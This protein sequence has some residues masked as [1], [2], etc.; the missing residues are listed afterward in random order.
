MSEVT[1]PIPDGID[2][3]GKILIT[4]L[5]SVFNGIVKVFRDDFG[6]LSAEVA[7]VKTELLQN[8]KC[9]NDKAEE[10]IAVSNETAQIVE[11]VRSELAE[12]K[13]ELTV[14]RE[15]ISDNRTEMT[16]LR[17]EVV[18]LKRERARVKQ[19]TNLQ[20][21]YSRRDNLTIRGIPELQQGDNTSCDQLLRN[22]FVGSMSMNKEE[23][24][25]M[26]FVRVHRIGKPLTQVQNR[27]LAPPR[28]IIVRFN[29]YRDRQKVW[30]CRKNLGNTK[31]SVNE[32]FPKS[33][34]YNRRKLYPIY[35]LAKRS[36]AL[37]EK[38]TLKNDVLTVDNE[39]F[40]VDTINKLP[41]QLHPRQLC[42]KTD[43]NTYAFGGLYSEYCSFSNWKLVKFTYNNK[44]FTS[45]E[46]AYFYTMALKSK[47]FNTADKIITTTSPREIKLLGK[48]IKGFNVH[49][50]NKNK[51]EVMLDILRCKFSQNADLKQDLINTGDKKLVE[52][53]RSAYYAAGLSLMDKN[54]LDSAKYTGKN[55]LG[56]FLQT[57][58]QELK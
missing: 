3:W 54:I 18:E 53:G 8:S 1:I 16:T 57:I 30:E 35:K 42:Y 36:E 33:V 13:R 17:N 51:G 43:D 23:V 46:Q 38:V 44:P 34:E 52:S 48:N 28:S 32:N 40:T 55:K 49:S 10:A 20:E 31:Y 19:Q 58:R 29:D 50:W 5:N 25:A 24:D 6:K 7:T 21:V 11:G 45:S 26:R 37:R 41:D 47:D 56:E 27:T 39:K 9:S 4:S 2:E 15:V 14:A 22:F 12:L